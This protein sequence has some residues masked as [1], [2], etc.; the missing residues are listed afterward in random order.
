MK[1]KGPTK[2]NGKKETGLNS[3]E[4]TLQGSDNTEV[5]KDQ[6]TLKSDRAINFVGR[7][8]IWYLISLIF[9][10]P[11]IISL[12][13]QGLNLGIDFTGGSLLH[14]K[15]ASEIVDNSQVR[16][17]VE[18]FGLE[19]TPL[20]QS[21]EAQEFMIR[22]EELSQERID[23]LVVSLEEKLGPITV[24]RGENVGAVFGK[25]LAQ[26]AFLALVIA[27][28]LMLLYITVRFEFKFGAAAVIALLHDALVVTGIFSIFQIEVDGAFV[29]AIL[30]ILGYSINDTIVIFDR[31]RE[32]R[33]NYPRWEL[34]HLVN[35]SLTQTLARSINTV[36][37]VIF[38]LVA[39][40]LFGG[41]TIKIFTLAL[42]I[43][44]TIGAYSSICVASPIWIEFMKMG[45]NG[46]RK[47]A[48]G[49]R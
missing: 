23:E 19:K 14:I 36:L 2:G 4:G 31:I 37:T 26:K 10:I 29:A 9:I 11:G 3:E 20:V 28:L 38:C 41:T 49:V 25:E 21:S 48:A 6:S 13:V 7:R 43:G 27:S 15:V 39:L 40:L 33:Q 12:A 47:V 1:Q 24:L 18:S 46:K 30:T 22:T 35:R 34:V 8:K 45:K 32:N 44:V 42:L 5:T 16:T 17:A